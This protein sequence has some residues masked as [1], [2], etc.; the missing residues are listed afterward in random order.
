MSIFFYSS[1]NW[2]GINAENNFELA[3]DWIVSCNQIDKGW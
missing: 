2:F 3:F 1:F